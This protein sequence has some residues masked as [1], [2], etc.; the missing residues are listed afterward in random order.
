[1]LSL[2]TVHPVQDM[3]QLA[4]ELGPIYWLDMMG[5]PLGI[6]SGQ[7]LG[8]ELCDEK[9]FDKTTRG[10]LRRLRVIGGDAL[11]TADTQMPHWAEADNILPP[12]LHHPPLQ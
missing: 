12:T 10:T 9:R 3:M 6:V 2:G 5:S 8:N 11:F 7:E 4:R 1:L